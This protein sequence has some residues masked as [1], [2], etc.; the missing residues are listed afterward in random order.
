MNGLYFERGFLAFTLTL[1]VLAGRLIATNHP[2]TPS[3][4]PLELMCECRINYFISFIYVWF[5]LE[6]LPST[7]IGWFSD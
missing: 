3:A 7:F 4:T 2:T 5:Q 6:M 1:A